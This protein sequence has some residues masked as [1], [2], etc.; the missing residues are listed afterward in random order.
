MYAASKGTYS[1]VRH[2][3]MIHC[4]ATRTT[5]VAMVPCVK[6]KRP[7]YKDKEYEFSG[8]CGIRDTMSTGIGQWDVHPERIARALNLDISVLIQVGG[9]RVRDEEEVLSHLRAPS[10]RATVDELES[11]RVLARSKHLHGAGLVLLRGRACTHL[12]VASSN[13]SRGPVSLGELLRGLSYLR[14]RLRSLRWLARRG[15]DRPNPRGRSS[16]RK[17]QEWS[18][19][20]FL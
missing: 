12:Y 1:Q 8:M 4:A 11:G 9:R 6:K 17:K 2:V 15:S 16:R 10:H 7:K 13:P 14:R 5:R 18:S 20:R 3:N 19:F